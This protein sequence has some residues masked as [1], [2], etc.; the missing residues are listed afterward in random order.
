MTSSNLSIQKNIWNYTYIDVYT[1]T[2]T[3]KYSIY[4]H[5]KGLVDFINDWNIFVAWNSIFF[6]NPPHR[7]Q[8][9]NTKERP[10]I[11]PFGCAC[12][13]LCVCGRLAPRREFSLCL[14]WNGEAMRS[15]SPLMERPGDFV[16]G[17]VCACHTD[18][19]SFGEGRSH[20]DQRP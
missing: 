6:L 8:T 15:M 5:F 3:L 19:L 17:L 16:D 13:R 4:I 20:C 2:H 7:L 12:A 11:V 9:F 14:S 18:P 1:H 10:L